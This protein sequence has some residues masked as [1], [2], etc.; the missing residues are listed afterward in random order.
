MNWNEELA[1]V[2]HEIKTEY[3][4]P[5]WTFGSYEYPRSYLEDSDLLG[6]IPRLAPGL[7]RTKKYTINGLYGETIEIDPS[8]PILSVSVRAFEWLY[9]MYERGENDRMVEIPDVMDRASS[10]EL[11][12][13]KGAKQYPEFVES[14]SIYL[15][16]PTDDTDVPDTARLG[17]KLFVT[18]CAETGY[19][20]HDRGAVH[21][22]HKQALEFI[23]TVGWNPK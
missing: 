19:E 20:G 13:A 23:R 2:C 17:H 4:S 15:A 21:V 22:G 10:L 9:P 8:L 5:G 6:L 14:Y 7:M 18:E 1:R 11:S 16:Q 3:G 12:I